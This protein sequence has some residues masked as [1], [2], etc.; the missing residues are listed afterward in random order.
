M[1]VAIAVVHAGNGLFT[2]N[3][4]WEYPLTILLV[5]LAFVARGAGRYSLD[6]W[7][8][9]R[10][11]PELKQAEKYPDNVATRD[12]LA[13]ALVKLG[14]TKSVSDAAGR[15]RDDA[16]HPWQRGPIAM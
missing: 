14:A 16:G 4:G 10:Q 12:S 9:R 7:L 5:S 13:L 1:I 8:K 11:H 15:H 6:A 2:Q 3:G